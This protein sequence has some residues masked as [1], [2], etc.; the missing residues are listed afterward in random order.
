MNDKP[1]FLLGHAAST[2]WQQ[3]L[4]SCLEQLGEVPAEANLGF[5]YVTDSFAEALPFIHDRLC[6]ATG[7]EHWTGTV[8]IGICATATEYH[9]KK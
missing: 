9:K 7:V 2:D 4:A 6:Q 8:G 3:A 1:P 5:V